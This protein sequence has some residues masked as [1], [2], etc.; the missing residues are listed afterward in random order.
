MDDNIYGSGMPMGFGFALAQ[1]MAAMEIFSAM[2]KKKQQQ[3]IEHT[4]QIQSKSEMQQYVDQIEK[5][6]P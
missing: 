1:N 5:G 4:H 3:I 2:D 6:R